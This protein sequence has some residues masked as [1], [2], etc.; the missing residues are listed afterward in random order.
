MHS[1]AARSPHNQHMSPLTPSTPTDAQP[2]APG[3]TPL[4]PFRPH[5]NRLSPVP[6]GRQSP[7]AQALGI[8]TRVLIG[9]KKHTATWGHVKAAS[10]VNSYYA[11]RGQA[12]RL[13]A[14]QPAGGN[15]YIVDAAWQATTNFLH[16]RKLPT[17]ARYSDTENPEFK[18]HFPDNIYGLPFSWL[19]YRY[20]H[21]T[22]T[23]D[24]TDQLRVVL[25]ELRNIHRAANP[26]GGCFG[27]H[28][29]QIV[30]REHRALAAALVIPKVRSDWKQWASQARMTTDT[31]SLSRAHCAALHSTEVADGDVRNHLILRQ[32]LHWIHGYVVAVEYRWYYELRKTEFLM[33]PLEFERHMSLLKESQ[34]FWD[35]H[36]REIITI[37][38]YGCPTDESFHARV[39]HWGTVIRAYSY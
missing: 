6:G 24:A 3:N 32:W 16:L 19:N 38:R 28:R 39:R 34:H 21:V 10:L 26:T 35:S 4:T 30:L 33:S 14:N 9:Q 13:T 15:V 11:K 22:P 23:W 27:V 1:D 18:G 36:D 17:W 25:D 8:T 12:F 29:G 20:R 5:C 2:R 7:I 37:M 31:R